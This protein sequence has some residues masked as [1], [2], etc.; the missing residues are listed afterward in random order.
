MREN[1]D[2]TQDWLDEKSEKFQESDAGEA[3]GAHIYSVEEVLDSIDNLEE[4]ELDS[5]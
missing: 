5:L 4:V 3:L 1:L 2:E